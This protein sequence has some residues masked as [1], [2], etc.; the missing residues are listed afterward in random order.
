MLT[1][2][3][4]LSDIIGHHVNMSSKSAQSELETLSS[5]LLTYIDIS[6]KT[7]WHQGSITKNSTGMYNSDINVPL[8][9]SVLS[10]Q[11]YLANV[12][13]MISQDPCHEEDDESDSVQSHDSDNAVMT[14]A[15]GEVA[16]E[17]ASSGSEYLRDSKLTIFSDVHITTGIAT[18]ASILP[19]YAIDIISRPFHS[20]DKTY[21][22]PFDLV[23]IA[24]IEMERRGH[25]RRK[26]SKETGDFNLI[27]S[28]VTDDVLIEKFQSASTIFQ[29]VLEHEPENSIDCFCWH[30]ASVAA[31]MC[32]GSGNQLG[33]GA[34]IASTHEHY[35]LDFSNRNQPSWRHQEFNNLR[36]STSKVFREFLS[37][38]SLLSNNKSRYHLGVK[39]QIQPSC[40][41]VNYPTIFK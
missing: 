17:L 35:Q 28:G 34:C 32:I 15:M 18:I 23:N 31:A 30:L 29:N 19:D 11:T 38:H 8:A 24:L 36:A 14:N 41:M 13:S 40:R 3:S 5:K 9:W 2:S 26:F 12:T 25:I 6:I 1:T 20:D 16:G 21:K 39:Y 22:T 10:R 37:F 7:I 4:M 33:K 27:S